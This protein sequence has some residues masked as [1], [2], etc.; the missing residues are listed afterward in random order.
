MSKVPSKAERKARNF[1][2]VRADM[3]RL[4]PDATK[5]CSKCKRVLSCTKFWFNLSREDGLAER[6][7]DCEIN[8]PT[9]THRGSTMTRREMALRDMNILMDRGGFPER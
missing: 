5:R 2:Q 8:N 6:C 4:H 7:S 1:E 9:K 3:L